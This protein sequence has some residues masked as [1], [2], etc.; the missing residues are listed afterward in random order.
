MLEDEV[1][2]RNTA[3]WPTGASGTDSAIHRIGINRWGNDPSAWIALSANP[4]SESGGWNGFQQQYWPGGSAQ[5]SESAD[6][7]NDCIPNLVEYQ[8][9]TSPDA[10]NA[11]T[12]GAA[13]NKL[14][15]NYTLRLDRTDRLLRAETSSTLQNDWV[16]VINDDLISTSGLLQTRQAWVPMDSTPRK[17]LRLYA[18]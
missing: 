15:L 12:H 2:Y 9:G 7:D 13:A 5:N 3:P 18:E 1:L 8:T 11:F 6:P 10:F 14:I 17:F 16:P 4:G